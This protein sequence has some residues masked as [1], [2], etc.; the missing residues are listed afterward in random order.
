M[1]TPINWRKSS[2]TVPYPDVN[3]VKDLWVKVDLKNNRT[4]HLWWSEGH[5]HDV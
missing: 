1:R 4:Y 3:K 2:E 5:L